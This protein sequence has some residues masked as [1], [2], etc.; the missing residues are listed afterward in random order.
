MYTTNQKYI[1]CSVVRDFHNVHPAVHFQP[2]KRP[3]SPQ[4]IIMLPTTLPIFLLAALSQL[5]SAAPTTPANHDHV[6]LPR[7]DDQ[8]RDTT[9]GAGVC[10]V[11]LTLP[12]GYLRPSPRPLTLI[13]PSQQSS[14]AVACINELAAKGSTA[15]RAGI[16]TTFCKHGTCQLF[17]V[18]E[19]AASGRDPNYVASSSW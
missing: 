17:G 9:P 14:D 5:A 13:R 6:L 3:P 7:A 2:Q 4:S 12:P 11:R 16:H 15:C 8:C 1:I 10:S 19:P 18:S